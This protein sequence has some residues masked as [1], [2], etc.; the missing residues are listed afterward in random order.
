MVREPRAGVAAAAA[1]LL[2]EQLLE[3]GEHATRVD[4]GVDEIAEAFL[5]R[6][7][8]GAAAELGEHRGAP[9]LDGS[10]R[11]GVLADAGER[12]RESDA[13][14][15]ALGLL[16]LLH[17]VP[18]H[19]VLDLVGDHTG[20]LA[21]VGGIGQDAAIDVDVAARNGEGVD[22]FTVHDGEPPGEV[23]ALGA[24]SDRVAQRVHVGVDRRV[25]QHGQLR[26]HLCGGLGAHL[27]LLLLRDGAGARRQSDAGG[28]AGGE[29]REES[30]SSHEWS[31]CGR[32]G[33]R[34]VL[35]RVVGRPFRTHDLR[36]PSELSGWP[37]AHVGRRGVV[38]AGV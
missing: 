8:L 38:F 17:R 14:V 25:V 28:E 32:V 29:A 15:R 35:P 31:R 13:D 23:G 20:Q 12:A 22:D 3:E 6:F 5:V 26:I 10:L 7:L 30:D 27:H 24:T 19:D 34:M 9:D 33:T 11:R 16:H 1:L 37:G 18:A 36:Q 4:P 2:G 21:L